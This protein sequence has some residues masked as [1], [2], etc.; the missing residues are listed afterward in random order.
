[1]WFVLG[2]QS[3]FGV[4]YFGFDDYFPQ[5]GMNEAGLFFDAAAL[6]LKEPAAR[7][8]MKRANGG[9]L[10]KMM[11]ECV[12]VPQALALLGRYDLANLEQ[13]QLLLADRSGAS[14]IVERNHVIARQGDYQIAT[15]FRQSRLAPDKTE[16]WR[17]QKADQMLKESRE[18]SV[19]R[20]R[21]ILAATHQQG[22]VRTLY[23][24]IYDLK[25]GDVYVYHAHDFT[26]VVRIN[27]KDELARGKH[28]V[29][30]KSLF[31]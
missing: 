27:L 11:R 10:D 30:L 29:N 1:M 18:F 31:P 13:A 8:G 14:A 17:Y 12:T 19:D 23:S 26:R 6:P 9:I 24:N 28:R 4:V 25:T 21:A 22:P 3:R 20:F 5:G 15:N 7:A 2:G 16:C